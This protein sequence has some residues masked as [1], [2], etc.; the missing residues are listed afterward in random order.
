MASVLWDVGRLLW[1]VTLLGV[2][3][4]LPALIRA[5]TRGPSLVSLIDHLRG[6]A[7]VVIVTISVLSPLRL[8]NPFTLALAFACWPIS[9]VGCQASRRTRPRT[10]RWSCA[11]PSSAARYGGNQE[12]AVTR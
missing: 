7:L 10:P 2:I 5:R 6:T 4:C 3:T 9:C 11:G 12:I 1:L 8:L